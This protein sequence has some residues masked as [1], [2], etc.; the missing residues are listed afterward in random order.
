MIYLPDI[1]A[2]VNTVL[3]NRF[4]SYPT[5]QYKGIATSVTVQRTSGQIIYPSV[6]EMNGSVNTIAF[7]HG[8]PFTLYHRMLSSSFRKA[9]N[10]S[11]FGDDQRTMVSTTAAQIVV[12]GTR[13]DLNVDPVQ[14]CMQIADSLPGTLSAP[15]Y[16]T[17]GIRS[18]NIYE[19]GIDFDQQSIFNKEFKGIK[20]FIGPELFLLAVRYT[21]EGAYLRGCTSLCQC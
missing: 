2:F 20:Y 14:L 11:T 8:A 5:A 15:E 17:L 7:N 1:V 3:A 12:M 21:I 13:A 18:V 4:T 10:T 19:T 16:A 6:I 9:T